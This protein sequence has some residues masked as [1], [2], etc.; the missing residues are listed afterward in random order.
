MR[1]NGTKSESGF[2]LIEMLVA[3]V[4]FAVMGTMAYGGLQSV[5]RS[6][7]QIDQH[8][9]EMAR[10]QR[11]L[12][13]FGRDIEQFVDRGARDEYGSQLKSIAVIDDGLTKRLEFTRTG[14]PNPARLKRS[15]Q[16]R[17]AYAL[18]EDTLVYWRWPTLDRAHDAQPIRQPL[19]AGLNDLEYRFLASDKKWYADWPPLTIGEQVPDIPIALEV[20]VSSESIGRVARLFRI[21]SN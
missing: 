12:N 18:D 10:L 14:L 6:R 9:D 1:Q 4:V 21:A 17:V 3:M 15:V 7:A 16:Q 5:I 11:V 13:Q 2:T 19:M 20:S 8:A